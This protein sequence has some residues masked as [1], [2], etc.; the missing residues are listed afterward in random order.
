MYIS[1]SLFAWNRQCVTI[2]HQKGTLGRGRELLCTQVSKPVDLSL[3]ASTRQHLCTVT[4]LQRRYTQQFEGVM[5]ACMIAPQ[6]LW[7]QASCC[8]CVA[9]RT[10]SYWCA[11]GNYG[12]RAW[13]VQRMPQVKLV[14][15]GIEGQGRSSHH[16]IYVIPNLTIGRSRGSR[17]F[18]SSEGCVISASYM[19]ALALS[20][21]FE[22]QDGTC[23]MSH[24]GAYE[25]R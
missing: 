4:C 17:A 18:N 11:T 7:N 19:N 1:W 8:V 3:P 23:F 24:S 10:T 15:C 20:I 13:T 14:R 6:L 21:Q 5:Q 9:Q 2:S 12:V 16:V 22:T 25:W